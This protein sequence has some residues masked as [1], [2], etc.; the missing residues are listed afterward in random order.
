LSAEA[1]KDFFSAGL[2]AKNYKTVILLKSMMERYL[3]NKALYHT[4]LIKENK[5]RQLIE[6]L[7]ISCL[8][9]T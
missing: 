6:A 7:F 4:L 8:F 1:G 2:I 5:K 9:F 3:R